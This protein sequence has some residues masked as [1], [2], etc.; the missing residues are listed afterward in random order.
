MNKWALSLVKNVVRVEQLRMFAGSWFQAEGAATENERS[1]KWRLERGM[2]KSAREVNQRRVS[3][4]GSQSWVRYDGAAP[5]TTR[6]IKQHSLYETLASMGSQCSCC[7]RG[8]DEL[9][10]G[11]LRTKRRYKLRKNSLPDYVV[12]SDT[13]N[14]FKNRLDAHWKQRDFL[15]HYRATYTGTGD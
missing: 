10:G 15:F 2:M 6:Y 12:M 7:K 8:R 13:I 11:A 9:R 4:H 5:W 3:R 14:T 1:A